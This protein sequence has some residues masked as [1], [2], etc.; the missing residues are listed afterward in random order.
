M[1]YLCRR[2]GLS[3]LILIGLSACGLSQTSEQISELNQPAGELKTANYRQHSRIVTTPTL[4]PSSPTPYV[5]NPNYLLCGTD[6]I[7]STATIESTAIPYEPRRIRLSRADEGSKLELKRG[8]ILEIRLASSP[9][10]GFKWVTS[11]KLRLLQQL[12]SLEFE[13]SSILSDAEGFEILVFE[14]TDVGKT[15]LSFTDQRIMD[16]TNEPYSLFSFF[17]TITEP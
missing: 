3:I 10:I 8:D 12:P 17:M 7:K 16:S 6:L 14:A 15:R 1:N 4:E 13:A 2:F 11:P 5:E 9:S